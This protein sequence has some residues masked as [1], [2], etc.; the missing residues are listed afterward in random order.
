M[1]ELF[2][3]IPKSLPPKKGDDYK[4]ISQTKIRAVGEK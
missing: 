1:S 2:K 3:T 4:E